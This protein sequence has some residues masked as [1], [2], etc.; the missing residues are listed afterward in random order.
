MSLLRRT[1]LSAVVLAVVSSAV[2]LAPAT[3][4]DI[5]LSQG[6]PVTTSSSESSSFSGAKAVDGSG[7][8]RWASAEGSDQQWLR[9]DLG[10]VTTVRRIKLEWEA[11][12]ATKYRLEISDDGIA[13]STVVAVN[14][15]DGKTDDLTGFTASGRYLRFV[16]VTRATSYG[17]SFWELQAYGSGGGDPQ[18]PT[19]PVTWPGGAAVTV[20]DG[21]NVFGDNLSGLSFENAD[22]LWAVRNGPSTLYR[23]V[24]DGALWKPDPIG[25]RT[26]N[27]KNGSGDPDAEAVVHTPDGLLVATERDGDNSGISLTK[28]LRY[29]PK[30]TAKTQ[31]ATAEWNLTSDLPS[32]DNNSGPEAISWIPDSFLTAK[33]LRDDRTNA[34]YNP[35]SY[36]NHGTGLYFVGL[37]ANGMVYA[38]AL[39]QSG[40]TFTRVA[41]FAGGQASIMDLEFEPET[42]L[43][44]STCDDTCQ[45]R[46]TTLSIVA[47]K[48]TV[49]ATYDRPTGLPDY[50]NEGFAITPQSACAAGRKQVIWADDGN[51]GG[52]AL[53]AGTLPCR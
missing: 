15:G 27:Y 18:T 49:A 21:S 9:V 36:A 53:R 44:W 31:N 33:G 19:T 29:D 35:A 14:N 45:N 2:L 34:A 40:G 23:L 41:A 46:S 7:T 10:S 4:A 24:R 13:Y 32:V 28:V 25:A 47:G 50:N 5:L 37:E 30:S 22:T 39:N 20:A 3:A 42:G 38:Y 12:Y 52:H 11:A 26:L 16:G 51:N 17:Y 43:L 1:T 6:K 48:F 8:T